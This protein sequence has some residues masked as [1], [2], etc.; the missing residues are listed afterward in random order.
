M[1]S[2]FF[3]STNIMLLFQF[4]LPYGHFAHHSKVRVN[5]LVLR[6]LRVC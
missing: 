3:Q 1:H 5:T 2:M 4:W 6:L